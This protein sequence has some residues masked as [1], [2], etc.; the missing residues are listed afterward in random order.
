MPAVRAA[1]AKLAAPVLLN[2]GDLAPMATPAMVAE[3]ARLFRDATVGVQIRA[4]HFPWV[5][6]P[7]AF[8]AAGSFLC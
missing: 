5:E 4:A 7:A 3:A 6:D 1:L 8:A 2:A